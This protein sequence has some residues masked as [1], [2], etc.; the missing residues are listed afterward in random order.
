MR[1][2]LFKCVIRLEHKTIERK[3][4]A[5]DSFQAWD[6]LAAEFGNWA[7]F[8]IKPIDLALVELEVVK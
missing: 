5:A 8:D 4:W 1:L 3:L 2:Q 7:K 6:K